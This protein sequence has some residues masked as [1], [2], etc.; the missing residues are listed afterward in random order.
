MAALARELGANCHSLVLDVRRR[1]AVE[2]AIGTLPDSHAGID[3]LVN[4]AGLALGFGPAQAADPDDWD[5][6]VDTNIKGLLYCTR[7]VLPAMVERDRGHV[8]NVGSIGGYYPYP[9][10]NVYGATKS[11]VQ[12]FSLI[13]RADLLGK[14]VRVTCVDPGLAE[15]EFSEVRFRGDALKAAEI[16]RNITP[17]SGADVADGIYYVATLPR[18]VNI[19]VLEMMPVMQAFSGPA[20]S[21]VQ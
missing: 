10:G 6:M 19:N 15:T 20:F 8:I 18:H 3:V 11:F 5:T 2:N 4:N 13:L 17:L 7:T 1:S 21:R 16:Y 9:N 14:N 12:H